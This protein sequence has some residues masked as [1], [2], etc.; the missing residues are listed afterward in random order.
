MV[1]FSKQLE[2]QLVP[3]W[4]SA[5]CNYWKLKKELKQIR[6]SQPR[7][8][9]ATPRPSVSS[10][11]FNNLTRRRSVQKD[12]ILVHLRRSVS[13]QREE[14]YETELVEPVAEGDVEKAF[15]ATL[16]HQ[17][18]KVNQFYRKK[19]SLFLQRGEEIKLQ[20]E[21]LITMRKVF[22]L[23]QGYAADLSDIL[24]QNN[25]SDSEHT[26]DVKPQQS[27]FL[28]ETQDDTMEGSGSSSGIEQ[29][30]FSKLVGEDNFSAV[31]PIEL[32][33][34][35]TDPTLSIS[36]VIQMLWNDV[37]RQTKNGSSSWKQFNKLDRKKI[38]YA[39]KMLRMAF[40]ELYRGLGLL[41]S[42]S[43]LNMVAFT[44]ILKKYDK[45]TGRD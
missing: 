39:E 41:R 26:G 9:F 37:L 17:L 21:K 33:I 10:L 28:P 25:L 35:K 44:K 12:V 3:E 36:A 38:Q 29:D 6:L 42:F 45:I 27:S 8:S 16:D 5:F 34:P 14:Y 4:K 40:V 30:D 18:N 24:A 2:S 19:E 23:H 1:K 43:Y 20:L 22:K 31:S 32:D 7:H 15:F 11:N 13:S